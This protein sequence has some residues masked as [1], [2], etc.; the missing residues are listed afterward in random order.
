MEHIPDIGRAQ[1][2]YR[3]FKK[4]LLARLGTHFVVLCSARN[5]L[6]SNPVTQTIFTNVLSH[7]LLLMRYVFEKE[8]FSEDD[9][10][11][12]VAAALDDFELPSRIRGYVLSNLQRFFEIGES[13][14]AQ[15]HSADQV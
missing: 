4:N 2:G 5:L 13:D 8:G 12:S 14:G 7:E 11:Q 3:D 6:D 9:L 15:D 1:K 10:S